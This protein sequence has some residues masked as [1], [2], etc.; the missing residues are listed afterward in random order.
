MQFEASYYA[1]SATVFEVDVQEGTADHLV[2]SAQ[3]NTRVYKIFPERLLFSLFSFLFKSYELRELTGM[4]ASVSV[5]SMVA[6][7]L[8]IVVAIFVTREWPHTYKV[9][10]K[11]TPRSVLGVRSPSTSTSTSTST[12]PPTTA[13]LELQEAL[14]RRLTAVADPLQTVATRLDRLLELMERQLEEQNGQAAGQ[15]SAED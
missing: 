7:W 13:Q 12:P 6:T 2:P 3:S 11:L 5:V 10:P 15:P 8:S 14:L 4:G 1:F 9:A